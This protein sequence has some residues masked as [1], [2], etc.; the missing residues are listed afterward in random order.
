[1]KSEEVYDQKKIKERIKKILG[2]FWTDFNV[3]DY[4]LQENV[5]NKMSELQCVLN[6]SHREKAKL[7]ISASGQGIVDALF[8]FLVDEYSEKYISLKEYKF[9]EF[10]IKAN[11]PAKSNKNNSGTDIACTAQIKISNS[12]NRIFYFEC[13]SFSMTSAAILVVLD[14][15]EFIVNAETAVVLTYRSLKDAQKRNREDLVAEYTAHLAE[16][17]EITC[18][19]NVIKKE[20]QND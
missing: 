10:S 5:K 20:R 6:V 8:G 12:R 9:I 11:I 16:L 17:V 13:E 2:N 1:M 7:N 4:S 14:V 3:D 18:F 19:S 15:V